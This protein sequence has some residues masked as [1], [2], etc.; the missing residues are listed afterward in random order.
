VN[1]IYCKICGNSDTLIVYN[2]REMMFGLGGSFSYTECQECYCLQLEDVP[3]D[4]S[5]FYPF[6]Y[7]SFSSRDSKSSIVEYLKAKRDHYLVY[8]QGLIGRILA[9][10]IPNVK[11]QI[12]EDVSISKDSKILDVGCGS[13][14]LLKELSRL[15][16]YNMSGV[17]PYLEQ[18]ID[19]G[20]GLKIYKKSIHEVSDSQ[21]LIMFH[22]SFEHLADPLE[23]MQAVSRLLNNNG[24]CIIRVPTTSSF[25]WEHYRENWVQL[26]AP[27]HLFLHSQESMALLAGKCSLVIEK[28]VYD[29]SEFQFLGSERYL[30]NI[31][32]RS[33]TKDKDLFTNKEINEYKRR[34]EELNK[35]KRGDACAFIIKKEN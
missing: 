19:Y 16:F 27:R 9:S 4:M 34:A 12:L 18:E 32:L 33:E 20:N 24:R 10:Q 21:D 25:S 29:S 28:I 15:G 5:Q 6:N 3:E 1:K 7:Y 22:H 17:D 2:A 8:K 23:T 30:K 13:G 31:P 11:M 14:G 26:D 35:Q